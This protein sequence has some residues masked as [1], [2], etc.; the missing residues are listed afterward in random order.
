MYTIQSK[1]VFSTSDG[2]IFHSLEKAKEHYESL[3]HDT[4]KK[5]IDDVKNDHPRAGVYAG[6]SVAITEWIL[7]NREWL[8]SLL[9]LNLDIDDES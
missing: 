7:K 3:I 1:T 5:M 9:N 4:V 8:S 2:K 6:D